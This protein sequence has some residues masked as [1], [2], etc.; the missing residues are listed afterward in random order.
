[1]RQKTVASSQLPSLIMP[2]PVCT[3]R[4][5]FRNIA[6]TKP[7]SDLEDFRPTPASAAGPRSSARHFAK[8][9]KPRLREACG[10][11][12][13]PVVAAAEDGGGQGPAL[14]RIRSGRASAIYLRALRTLPH[15]PSTDAPSELML[16]TIA[17]AIPAAIIEYSMAVA[18][19]TP[20]RK[21]IKDAFMGPSP[22]AAYGEI[23]KPSK[24]RSR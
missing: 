5:V 21:R 14:R 6:P 17:S 15:M 13:R 3:G 4:L 11:A 24:I 16:A 23:G 12:A 18:P 9:Q 8:Q 7:P 20:R 1:M 2:C 22:R 19:E 10:C